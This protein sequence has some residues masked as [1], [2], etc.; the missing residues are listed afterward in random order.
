MIGLGRGRGLGLGA[1]EGRTSAVGPPDVPSGPAV[2]ARN[3]AKR[4][5]LGTQEIRA[6]DDVSFE[7]HPGEFVAL[8]GPSGSG[9]TSMLAML[10]GLL[11]PSGGSVRIADE[12]IA[13]L[14]DRELTRFR[15]RNIGFTFQA[16]NLLPY[17]TV[18]ENVLLMLSLNGRATP[19]ARDW[20]ESLLGQL[21]LADRLGNLPSQLSGGQRQRV[22]IARALIHRPAVVLADEPTASLDTERAYQVVE[23]FANLVHDERRA[24]I[25]VTHDLR[26]CRFVDRV[27]VMRDGVLERIVEGADD[28][29]AF[30][31]AGP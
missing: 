6:V 24:G 8:V 25:M 31:G 21:G 28:V 15:R 20:A 29:A 7:V 4:Y 9:K 10:A 5:T 18:L 22:S 3:L 11:R 14:T 30:A 23:T 16:N 17:L 27:I 26:M 13:D 2:V 19:A 12:E 1:P